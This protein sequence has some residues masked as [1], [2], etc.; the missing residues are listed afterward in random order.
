MA[1]GHIVYQGSALQSPAHFGMLKNGS[2]KYQNPCDFFMRELAINYPKTEEDQ[3]K[4][5]K[6]VALYKEKLEIRIQDEI[7]ETM[8]DSIDVNFVKEEQ[9]GFA[10][11]FK[12]LAHR[13]FLYL[14]REPKAMKGKVAQGIFNGFIMLSLY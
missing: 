12:Q 10:L 8:V 1:D 7:Q 14:W 9:A 11:Q 4:I 5:E 2:K 6:Y 3:L 13:Y